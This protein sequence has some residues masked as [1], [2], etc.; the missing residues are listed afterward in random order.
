MCRTVGGKPRRLEASSVIEWLSLH[1]LFTA[2]T[3]NCIFWGATIRKNNMW[4]TLALFAAIVCL[5]TADVQIR[6]QD[7]PFKLDVASRGLFGPFPGTLCRAQIIPAS[8]AAQ[9]TPCSCADVNKAIAPIRGPFANTTCFRLTALT[10]A[11]LQ[12]KVTCAA[13]D[14]IPV[15]Q[16]LRVMITDSA[17][18]CR[19]QTIAISANKEARFFLLAS[20]ADDE[21]LQYHVRNASIAQMKG[22]LKYCFGCSSSIEGSPDIPA[23]WK[24]YQA[25]IDDFTITRF[26]KMFAYTPPTTIDDGFEESLLFSA[27]D[28]ADQ[29]CTADG[30]VT[31]KKVQVD[32]PVFQP[33]TTARIYIGRPQL[34]RFV[35]AATVSSLRFSLKSVPD[36][37]CALLCPLTET[38]RV[39]L[40]DYEGEQLSGQ[41]LEPCTPSNALRAGADVTLSSSKD[42]F[43][44][45]T[46]LTVKALSNCGSN[47]LSLEITASADG[48]EATATQSLQ[49]VEVVQ[50]CVPFERVFG[51]EPLRFQADS[52]VSTPAAFTATTLSN[53]DFELQHAGSNL[54]STELV[55][56]SEIVFSGTKSVDV[57]VMVSSDT[58]PWTGY[59]KLSF[60]SP[61]ASTQG[62]PTT[63]TRPPTPV[64]T[65]SNP[66]IPQP[67][68]PATSTSFM[69]F[70]VGAV[71]LFG[72]LFYNRA[73]FCSQPAH[74]PPRRYGVVAHGESED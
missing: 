25:L 3:S 7:L 6:K 54:V 69:W 34:L 28:A 19:N 66:E 53:A 62:P 39:T 14:F 31:F 17:P 67:T 65:S 45:Q 52:F 71:V 56:S 49:T 58:P 61:T 72:V 8:A 18:V 26:S 44:K 70:V 21:F 63:S 29:Q 57:I 2:G 41:V 73:R 33:L 64:P 38:A 16:N 46:F 1:Y 60:R 48:V 24:D 10:A 22:T 15:V 36:S 9:A 37:T 11:A 30:T 51:A 50:R 59:C 23:N 12:M 47:P 32:P 74:N 13:E 68:Q 40:R 4:F 35:A 5:V 20:D 55:A 42:T 43:F 27:K